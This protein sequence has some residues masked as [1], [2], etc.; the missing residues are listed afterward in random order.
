MDAAN[1]PLTPGL[2]STPGPDG[3]SSV[4]LVDDDECI[5]QSVG[6]V[7][8]HLGYT[9]VFAT[10]GEE[11]L[12]KLKAGL[13][14]VLVILDMDMPGMGGAGTLPLLR[15]LWPE[16]PVVIATGRPSQKVVELTQ[17]FPLVSMLP[18]P[19]GLRE[20]EERLAWIG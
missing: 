12:V 9:P 4:L 15:N 19:F 11:A 5:L 13:Q 17:C 7:L 16:L 8:T 14:P 10:T 3:K 6:S 2:D 1:H 20:I 18:K